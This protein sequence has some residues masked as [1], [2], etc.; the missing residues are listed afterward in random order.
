MKKLLQSVALMLVLLV[1][2][3]PLLA[4]SSCATQ[5]CSGEHA[6]ATCCMH[7]GGMAM[8]AGGMQSMRAA[9]TPAGGHKAVVTAG[10]SDPGCGMA[11]A[12]AAVP[13]AYP[14][15]SSVASDVTSLPAVAEIAADVVPVLGVRTAEDA[16]APATARYI[17]LQTFR[18]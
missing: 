2:A 14:S 10:C 5:R 4:A 8:A 11:T 3:Q 6:M 12:D 18:I 15:K 1:A 13:V 7:G 9:C 16:S 17:L